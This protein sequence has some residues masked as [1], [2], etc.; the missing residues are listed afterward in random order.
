AWGIAAVCVAPCRV[1]Q[2]VERLRATPVLVASA[3]G[4]PLGAST[5]SAKRFEAA[6]CVK[7]GADELDVVMNLGALKSGDG[8]AVRLDL[9]GIVEAAHAAGARVKAILELP[10]LTAAE[11]EEAAQLALAAGVDFLKTSTGQAGPAT[12]EQV[13]L[14]RRLAGGRARIKAAGGIR[15]AAQA[16]A[17]IAA[18]ADRLGTSTPKTVLG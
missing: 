7:L 16:R 4:F 10:L 13:E 14:L 6:E 3:V 5:A 1:A 11:Q 8:E 2:A 15:T 9:A 17:L 18:G 12:V